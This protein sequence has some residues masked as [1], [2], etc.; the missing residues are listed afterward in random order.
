MSDVV[1]FVLAGAGRV[2]I[3]HGRNLAAGVPGASL[4]A[5]AD[6]DSTMRNA[7][8][9][10][11]GCDLTFDNSLEGV[12]DDRIDAVVIS[13]PTSTHADLAIA[14]LDAGKHILCEKP[15]ASN[16]EEGQAIV[17]AMSKSSGT[18]TMAFMRRFD[19]RFRRAHNHLSAGA[20]G[21]PIL[22]RSSGRG[23]GL[24]PEW[25]WDP[26]TSGGL[27]AEVNSHDLDTIRWMSGQEFVSVHALGRASI[28]PDIAER[29]KGFVDIL[30]A[31]F[32]L[33]DGALGQLDGACPAGYGYDARVEIVGTEGILMVGGPTED[34][35]LLVRRDGAR[36]D[37][38]RSWR[39]LFADAYRAEV[40][41]VVAVARGTEEQL[42]SVTDGLRALEAVV[43]V[44]R[45]LSDGLP[46]SIG[47]VTK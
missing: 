40:A 8:A 25:A 29:Y 7:A 35:P 42:T 47:E 30:I 36:T 2:G 24:P 33:S 44:N 21:A 15:L 3:V 18:L 4:A 20:I 12:T 11:L 13:G 23:P 26:E 37:P 1:R 28:R 19:S 31:S 41:H 14:A 10:E 39:D 32:E 46:V 38:V 34:S 17:T 9:Q 5:I 43:A 22:V 45:S 16:I 6:P 27:V